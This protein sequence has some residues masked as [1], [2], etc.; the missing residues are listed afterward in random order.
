MELLLTTLCLTPELFAACSSDAILLAWRPS[1]QLVDEDDTQSH[2]PSQ[3]LFWCCRHAEHEAA[4][5]L[6]APSLLTFRPA[7]R[8]SAPGSSDAIL[9][10]HRPSQNLVD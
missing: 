3:P 6:S 1:R 7:P 9:L 5:P 2:K 10:A 4:A 8:L